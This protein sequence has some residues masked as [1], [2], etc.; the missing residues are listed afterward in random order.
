M[1]W[2]EIKTLR[3]PQKEAL[4]KIDKYLT[5]NEKEACLIHMPTGS[6][7]SGIISVVSNLQF[8]DCILIITPRVALTRQISNAVRKIFLKEILEIDE[9]PRDKTFRNLDSKMNLLVEEDYSKYVFFDTIHGLHWIR[10]NKP[11]LYKQLKHHIK[12]IIFDEAHYEPAYSWSKTIRKLKAK[13]ILFTATPFRNDLKPFDISPE[14]IYAYRYEQGVKEKYLRSIEFETNSEEKNDDL[15]LKKTFKYYESK[16]GVFS[17]T[18]P[19]LI[20]RCSD[21]VSILRLAHKIENNYNHIDYIAIH[22]KFKIKKDSKFSKSVPDP[23]KTTAKVWLHQNK[24]LEGI[25]DDQFKMLAIYDGFNN[26]RAL[27]Q[28]IGRIVRVGKEKEDYKAYVIDFCGNKHKKIWNTY[29]EFDKSLSKKSFIPMSEKV[30]KDIF[31]IGEN[32]EYLLDGFKEKFN[33]ETDSIP[34]EIKLPKRVNFIQ[35]LVEFNIKNL[36]ETTKERLDKDDKPYKEKIFIIDGKNI[37]VFLTLS[38]SYSPY[39]EGKYALNIGND[40]IVFFEIKDTLAYFD[41]TNYIPI[42]E[43]ELGLG[44]IKDSS[45]FKK[46]FNESKDSTLTSVSL[47]NSNL[48][49]NSIRSHS[50]SA[51][52]IDDT[53]SFLDDRA[54]IVSTASGKHTIVN[55]VMGGD[56]K[57]Q[58]EEKI[59]KTISRYSGITT[60]RISER[61]DW[62]LIDDYVL[63][64]HSIYNVMHNVN[65]TPKD[66]FDRYSSNINVVSDATPKHILLDIGEVFDDFKFSNDIEIDG[67]KIDKGSP[68][69]IKDLCSEV[70]P[71]PTKDNVYQFEVLLG[72]EYKCSLELV[73]NNS[74]KSYAISGDEFDQ[75]FEAVS[76][77][78][79]KFL[80]R[81]LN[82][83]QSFKIIPEEP[84]IIYAYGNFYKSYSNFGDDFDKD[85]FYLKDILIP[86][87]DMDEVISEK[88]KGTTRNK[89]ETWDKN[90]LFG[91]IDNP[92]EGSNDF[93]DLMKNQEFM[94]FD[95][96]CTEVADVIMGNNN[97]VAFIHAKYNSKN[98]KYSAT[99]LQDVVSQA[100]KNIRYLNSFNQLKPPNFNLWD[101]PWKGNYVKQKMEVNKRIRKPINSTGENIWNSIQD[102]IQNPNNE[103]EVWL[104]LGKTLSKSELIKEL[105]KGTYEAIQLTLL[106][107]SCLQSVGTVNAK[108]KVFC[109]P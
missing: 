32:I 62:I 82:S 89:G 57:T 35:K 64:V 17:K 86:L 48:G 51:N 43:E 105:K 58:K 6:G 45:K 23:K 68:I 59:T 96:M 5:T 66:T 87:N 39:I 101:G 25:D 9:N 76:N 93:I 108:L 98:S 41:S 7:K 40:L 77:P 80:T 91:R 34:D 21:R 102:I 14:Y 1:N 33:F 88:G 36:I 69:I 79:Y 30:M 83:R 52:S 71:H 61:G 53:V 95:D 19:K 47:K 92:H 107:H 90:S 37:H 55:T 85:K 11:E 46:L 29:L 100:T 54:H 74:K 20:I 70:I 16:F 8:E 65:I 78:Q 75:L 13:K 56:D 26:D 109:S 81:F 38:V 12:L 50:L 4:S 3:T 60:G 28:Q 106:L 44:R 67:Q 103:R 63:W 15:F 22:E 49:T 10:K 24:L 73:Y 31:G 94:V 72:D 42:G 2:K 104:M 27:I 18:S 97:K 99:A 84:N